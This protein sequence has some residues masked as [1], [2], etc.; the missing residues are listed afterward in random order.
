MNITFFVDGASRGNPGQAGAGVYAYSDDPRKPI[1]TISCYLGKAT[2]N[3][4]EYT[5]LAL[6][7]HHVSTL[8]NITSI[9]AYADSELLVKQING[10]YRVK[11]PVL[12][13]W[14]AMIKA[15]AADLP[16][17]LAHVRREK[18]VDADLLANAGIDNRSLLPTSF[19]ALMKRYITR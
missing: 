4:A 14:H 16:M 13:Q 7:V 1:F 18:N 15:I 9:K 19:S 6:A 2:N 10:I 8:P 3:V 5:A 11:N 17:K 12:M